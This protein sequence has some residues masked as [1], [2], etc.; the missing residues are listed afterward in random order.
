MM[1]KT[2]PQVLRS[3][4]ERLTAQRASSISLARQTQR[5]TKQHKLPSNLAGGGLGVHRKI[6]T[7]SWTAIHDYGRWADFHQADIDDNETLPLFSGT[8]RIRHPKFSTNCVEYANA[9]TTFG[10]DPTGSLGGD[11]TLQVTEYDTGDDCVMADAKFIRQAILQLSAEGSIPS[12][13]ITG[14]TYADI[15]CQGSTPIAEAT[16]MARA[17]QLE[18]DADLNELRKTRHRLLLAS[19][20]TQGADSPLS[21]SEKLRGLHIDRRFV[22]SQTAPPALT[23]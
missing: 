2:S 11:T 7:G 12:A 1:T 21:D 20:W 5:K 18:T 3:I 9:G 19:D 6:G 22:T 13:S 23:M 17:N 14:T 8:I 10:R 4:W 16:L 15:T